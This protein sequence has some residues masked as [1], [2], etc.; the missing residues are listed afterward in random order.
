M[1]RSPMVTWNCLCHH[2][3]NDYEMPCFFFIIALSL[4]PLNVVPKYKKK[5]KK[6]HGKEGKRVLFML[7]YYSITNRALETFTTW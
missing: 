2:N 7:M 1:I 3:R 4:N 6:L 5:K